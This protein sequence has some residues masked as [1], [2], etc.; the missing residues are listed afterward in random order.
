MA[1]LLMDGLVL[2]LVLVSVLGGFVFLYWS[3]SKMFMGIRIDQ[4]CKFPPD[5]W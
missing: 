3:F 4:C 2:V 5:A 1:N